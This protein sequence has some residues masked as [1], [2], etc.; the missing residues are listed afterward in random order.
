MSETDA[1]SPWPGEIAIVTGGAGDIG[2]EIAAALLARGVDV[3]AADLQSGPEQRRLDAGSGRYR[4]DQV[5]LADPR[6]TET[7]VGSVAQG[8]GIPT[9]AVLC[10]GI[11]GGARLVD[12]SPE[13]WRQV[14]G[15]CLD[16]AFYTATSVI[17]TMRQARVRGRI[18]TIGSWA[19]HAPHPHIGAYSVAKA[20]LRMLTQ[21]LALDHAE[22]GILVNEVA[23]GVVEAGL[24]KVLLDRDPELKQ[25]THAAI[26]L[27]RTLLP[28]Q[29]AREVLHLCSPANLTTTGAVV[30]S[31]GALSLATSMNPGRRH[32]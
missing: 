10:T 1:T 26:P 15:G 9:I 24:S 11:S 32:G 5:D 12:T 29:V 22:D 3:A 20:G 23:P 19:A 2:R 25:R 14:L 6:A 31:D 17:R 13:E 30:V 16:A 27:G 28:A 8:W 4:F 18:V 21:T 7:W